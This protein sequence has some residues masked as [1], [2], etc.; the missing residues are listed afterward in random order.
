ML[1]R[2]HNIQLGS[3]SRKHCEFLGVI[4]LVWN[5]FS[6]YTRVAACH[7]RPCHG[8]TCH[9]R[10]GQNHAMPQK[11]CVMPRHMCFV[12]CRAKIFI[13][14]GLPDFQITVCPADLSLGFLAVLDYRQCSRQFLV[15]K[16]PLGFLV[17]DLDTRFVS[18]FKCLMSCRVSKFRAVS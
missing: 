2:S 1:K 15:G 12:L 6:L 9:V 10:P 7:A 13:F 11:I 5:L 3:M 8:F 18:C 17:L 14:V 4:V 16:W